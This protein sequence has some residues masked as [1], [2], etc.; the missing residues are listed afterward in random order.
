MTQCPSRIVERYI[1]SQELPEECP[2]C[3]DY[4]ADE[5]GEPVY[6]ADPSFCS[7]HCRDVYMAEQKQKDDV[8]AAEHQD[9]AK[10]ISVHNAKCVRCVTSPVYCFHQEGATSANTYTID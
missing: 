5:N 1:A 6:K 10:L 9:V 2:V 7:S 8:E 3:G 4:N